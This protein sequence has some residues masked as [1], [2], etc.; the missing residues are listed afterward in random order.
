MCRCAAGESSGVCQS[1]LDKR[2]SSQVYLWHMLNTKASVF[3]IATLR[4]FKFTVLQRHTVRLVTSC[5]V[6]TWLVITLFAHDHLYA[7]LCCILYNVYAYI[8]QFQYVCVM[9]YDLEK[10]QNVKGCY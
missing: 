7:E 9:D 1:V 8:Q 10:S 4:L 6:N 3:F 2:I 5:L